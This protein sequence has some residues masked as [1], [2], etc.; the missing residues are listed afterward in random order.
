MASFDSQGWLDVAEKRP[1]PGRKTSGLRSETRGF[2]GHSAVADFATMMNI[3]DGPRE[4]SWTFSNTYRGKLYQHFPVGVKT[5]H[6]TVANGW[7][8]ALEHEGGRPGKLSEP[9]TP[10]QIETD[11]VVVAAL[12]ERYGWVT[13]SRTGP[14]QNLWEHREVQAT[15]CPSGRLDD[16]W[17]EIMRR[18][19]TPEEEEDMLYL[20]KNPDVAGQWFVHN[21]IT[22]RKVVSTP[23]LNQL[24]GE[25]AKE[26]D[27]SKDSFHAM[28]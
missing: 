14:K 4:A 11:A 3:L 12:R 16:A 17:V 25:G 6:A 2:F 5:W 18:A 28:S 8:V 20:S 13:L 24:R 22:K 1:G 15:A 10:E 7:G 23:E 9:I 19:L 27:I 26:I 21:M